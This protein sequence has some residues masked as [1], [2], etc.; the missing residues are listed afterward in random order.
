[1]RNLLNQ[2]LR[3]EQGATSIEYG[4]I[5]AFVVLAIVVAVTALGGGVKDLFTQVGSVF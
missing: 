1:M 4:M 2:F 3:S 5:A